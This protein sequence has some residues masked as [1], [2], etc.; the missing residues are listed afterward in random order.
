MLLA[1]VAVITY[2]WKENS[3]WTLK[4]GNDYWYEYIQSDILECLK[5]DKAWEENK[6]DKREMIGVFSMGI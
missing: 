2:G 6:R 1:A 5:Q 4:R 3:K